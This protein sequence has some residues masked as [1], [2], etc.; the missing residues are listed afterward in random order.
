MASQ[1]PIGTS[2]M[3]K[4]NKLITQSLTEGTQTMGS[5]TNLIKKKPG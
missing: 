2:L 1:D 4:L 5:L 3:E